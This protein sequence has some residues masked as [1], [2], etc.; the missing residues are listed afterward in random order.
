MPRVG[1]P[2]ELLHEIRVFAMQSSDVLFRQV[3][4]VDHAIAGTFLRRQQLIELQLNCQ[5]LFVLRALDQKD[6]QKRD[7]RRG[8]VDHQLPGLGVANKGT[9]ECPD[10]DRN[11]SNQKGPRAAS[12]V[13]RGLRKFLE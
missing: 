7:N 11:Y 12:E 2:I 10:D 4:N 13:R 6:H 1:V 5:R 9:G 3:F 8:G